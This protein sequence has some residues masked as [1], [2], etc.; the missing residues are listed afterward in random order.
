M[1]DVT[2]Q[3]IEIFLAA[4]SSRSI[5]Q[6]ARELYIS[7]PAVSGTL[8]K[9][10]ETVGVPLF[11]RTNRGVAL[12][13]EGARL[14]AELDPIYKRFR[15]A[16]DKILSGKQEKN[17][18]DLNMGG[19]HDP[20][21]M[22]CMRSSSEA[23]T[24]RFPQYTARFEYFNHAE[25][26]DKLLCEELDLSFTFSFKVHGR[27][28]FDCVRLCSLEQH[29]V[30]PAA[31][32][33]SVQN[34]FGFLR[35]KTLILET[36]GSRETMLSVCHAHDFEPAR[37]KYVNSYLLLA[38]MVAEGEGFSI[39]GTHLPGRA[40]YAARVAF[41]PVM[42]KDCNEYVHIVA[43]WRREDD[44]TLLRDMISVLNDSG[45]LQNTPARLSETPGSKWYR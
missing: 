4:A 39:G 26:L 15:I 44:R 1:S 38:Y 7:Q 34:G 42:A 19:F 41:V 28:E 16:A 35:D 31:W 36:S 3:Q 17:A 22:N 6:A 24:R 30:V 2:I 10:E 9:M 12:S 43:A 40:D 23:F 37:F 45:S 14:Y 13:N 8:R 25:L 29:F 20:D 21:V 33:A 18:K 32:A 27:P 5:S 11:T